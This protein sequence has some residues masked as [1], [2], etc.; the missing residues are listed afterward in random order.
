M[1]CSPHQTLLG[2]QI[3]ETVMVRACG[4][5]RGKLHTQCWWGNLYRTE[6]LEDL[7]VDGMWKTWIWACERN[8]LP[9]FTTEP[10]QLYQ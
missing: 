9:R 8:L 2:Y 7:E 5:Y 4:T 1:S 6:H 3:E 10:N